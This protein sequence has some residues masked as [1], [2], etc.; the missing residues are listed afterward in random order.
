MCFFSRGVAKL[1]EQPK[2]RLEEDRP[3]QENMTFKTNISLRFKENIINL[4]FHY[5]NC[6]LT[7][8][9]SAT[10]WKTAVELRACHQNNY[11]I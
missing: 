11:A 6:W 9:D 2:K 1:T 4:Y 5:F 3:I 7:R 8:S 10:H